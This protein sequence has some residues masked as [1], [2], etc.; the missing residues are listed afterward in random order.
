M[1]AT[2][3]VVLRGTKENPSYGLLIARLL[4]RLKIFFSFIFRKKNTVS[5]N[6]L[7]ENEL[8]QMSFAD[9]LHALWE[10]PQN[11][12]NRCLDTQIS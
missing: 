5:G 11:E 9:R 6:R 8:R 7:C 3:R 2:Q 4:T 1:S 10:I 12:P